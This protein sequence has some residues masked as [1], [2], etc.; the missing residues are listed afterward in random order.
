MSQFATPLQ[1]AIYSRLTA[2]SISATIYD[3]VPDLP[4]GMPLANFPYVAIGEDTF[5]P[6]S[7]DDTI[8][9]NA[10]IYLHV[11]SRYAG[12]KEVKIIMGEI[13]VALNRQSAALSAT[14]YRFIDCLPEYASVRDT[15][16]GETRHGILRYRVTIQ[17]E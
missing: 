5:L 2:A 3:D 15:N 7:T 11:W 8:G 13:D 6:W 9:N 14:G 16:D 4:A 12:K 1:Q 17:K 10:T